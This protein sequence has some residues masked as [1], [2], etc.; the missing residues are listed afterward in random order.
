MEGAV[1]HILSIVV[2]RDVSS[3]SAGMEAKQSLLCLSIDSNC[4]L[5]T[6]PRGTC[7]PG[8]TLPGKGQPHT[9]ERRYKE[10]HNS[11]IRKWAGMPPQEQQEVTLCREGR[12]WRKWQVQRSWG[13]SGAGSTGF[14]TLTAPAQRQALY[15]NN[16]IHRESTVTPEMRE[17][18]GWQGVSSVCDVFCLRIYVSGRLQLWTL[19][20]QDE[21]RH[22]NGTRIW[23]TSHTERDKA[24]HLER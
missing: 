3:P 10:G 7:P 24:G 23:E 20:I 1:R 4:F 13:G 16:M 9:S 17:R 5:R 19:R 12:K 18:E 2:S 21:R 22:W 15:D 8:A 6:R 11:G 14:C